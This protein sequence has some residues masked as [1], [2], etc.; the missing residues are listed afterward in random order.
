[1]KKQR[2]YLLASLMYAMLCVPMCLRAYTVEVQQ[3]SDSYS[4]M[5]C[6]LSDNSK[7]YFRLYGVAATRSNSYAEFHGATSLAT[8]IEVPDTIIWTT[9]DRRYDF[10]TG[11]YLE[12]DT[13]T[14]FIPVTLIKTETTSTEVEV[15][16]RIDDPNLETLIFPA[17]ITYIN[18]SFPSSVRNVHLKSAIPPTLSTGYSTYYDFGTRIVWVPDS[19]YS[20]Y[21]D[22]QSNGTSGWRTG[23]R[24]H[25]ESWTPNPIIV[26]VNT[27][28]T[29]VEQILQQV[30]DWH[31][32]TDLTVTGHLNRADLAN[33]SRLEYIERLDLSQT[34]ITQME[35]C[36]G[37]K[38]LEEVLLP[39]TA[40]T[41]GEKAFYSCTSLKTIDLYHV[42]AI[43]NNAF[44]GC[45]SL[46]SVNSPSLVE[47]GDYA[48]ENCSSLSEIDMEKLTSVPGNAFY[49]CSSLKKINLPVATTIDTYAFYSCSSLN[50]VSLPMAT[51]IGYAAFFNCRNLSSVSLPKAITINSYAFEYCPLDSVDL[52]MV[53]EI[54]SY[55]FYAYYENYNGITKYPTLRHVN[56]PNV[57]S[58]GSSAFYGQLLKE[59]SLPSSLQ[60]LGSNI[61]AGCDSLTDV[62]CHVALPLEISGSVGD[63]A[64]HATL[65]VPAF[66]LNMYAQHDS[67]NTFNQ[68]VPMDEE[69]DR[70]N[71][72]GRDC[73]INSYVGLSEKPCLMIK[74]HNGS[75]S[76]LTVE[77]G[78][79]WKLGSFT[80]EC[81]M[82][83]YGHPLSMRRNSLI[84]YNEITADTVSMK[85]TVYTNRW[86][87]ISFPFDVNVSE[88]EMPA[89]R[90]WVIRRYAG[91]NR[92]TRIGSTWQDMTSGMTLE[93]NKGYILHCLDN[94]TFND[95]LQIG[96]KAVD[97]ENK[98]RIFAYQDVE[99]PLNTY[100][101]ELEN[102]RSWNLVGNPYP[103]YFDAKY[104]EHNGIITLWNGNGYTPYSLT[105]DN[106]QLYPGQAF[107]VQ[108][109]EGAT[110]MTFKAEGRT[111]EQREYTTFI[112]D[113]N[114]K[115]RRVKSAASSA[116]RTIYNITLSGNDY[117]DRARVVINETAKQDYEISC[118]AS[119]FMSSDASVPQLYAVENGQRL[120]IDERPLGNGT[121]QLGAYFGT[122]GAYTIALPGMSE[123]NTIL[124]L[125]DNETGIATDLTKEDYTFTATKGSSDQRFTLSI[126]TEATGIAAV[127]GNKQTAGAAIYNMNGQRLSAPLRGVNIINGKKVLVR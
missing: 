16:E 14:Y 46:L 42:K 117:T 47:M 22:Y 78:S 32:V 94:V 62:Y 70:L 118:D 103:C 31:D 56:M 90:P 13:I 1:M 74:N 59:V 35:G 66:S 91:E 71:I 44:Y 68:I 54:G 9:Y 49:S 111:H 34:D 116:P 51:T 27:A 30:E 89:R 80:D 97:N 85:T 45:S 39:P 64:S 60:S 83:K 100:E 67:W 87:F 88:I 12:Q 11:N 127:N 106:C 8:V 92:A 95:Y 17:T 36:S 105:D 102:D 18:Y 69:I 23:Y 108:C 52:L 73:S 115:A 79:S 26:N 3:V 19:A 65:H 107:F 61:F 119:K 55:A 112:D 120:A 123:A 2:L 109:P 5:Y 37:L 75:N 20:T 93:A 6:T 10:D 72:I 113:S 76:K 40:T 98:N 38:Y 41:I 82:P 15:Y 77:A 48:F 99:L 114:A 84:S 57:V 121:V 25:K 43:Q 122:S 24:I 4:H 86:N 21:L 29:M 33:L 58:I 81:N 63:A 53:K 50:N 104:I 125:T 7:L 101:S 126:V 96:V 110:S 28:G 124:L